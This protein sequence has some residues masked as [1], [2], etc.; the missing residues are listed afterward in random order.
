MKE[1]KLTQGQ[2]AIVDDWMFDELNQF[3]W[4]ALFAPTTG[5]YYAMRQDGKNRNGKV[6]MHRVV[7][8]TP[9]DLFCDHIDGDTLN[10]QG[11]N[12]R[13]VTVSQNAINRKGADVDNKLGIRGVEIGYKGYRAYISINGKQKRFPTRR[14]L[15]EAI[16][17]RK[18]AEAQYYGEFISR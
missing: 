15:E 5:T 17:D 13:N 14:T 16:S 4:Y 12:L 2:V 11:F 7:A 8:R 9:A 1:I 18:Q 10:N 3:K 6:R